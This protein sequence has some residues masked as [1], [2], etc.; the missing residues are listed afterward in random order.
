MA[1]SAKRRG[2]LALAMLTAGLMGCSSSASPNASGATAACTS[3]ATNLAAAISDTEHASPGAVVC[4]AAGD[5]AGPISLD[6]SH[7]R[8]VTLQ[9]TPGAHVTVGAIT[10]AGSHT[11]LRDLWI[12]GE[13]DIKAGASFIT[14]DH[15]DITGGYFGVVFDASD[16]QVA[17]APK[18]P[19]CSPTEPVTN[20]TISGNHFHDI[21]LADKGEDAIHLDYWRNVAIRGNE[22][23]NIIESGNHT[24][25]LQSVYGGENL[26]FEHNYEHDNNCQGLFLKDGDVT[27]VT[28]SE[29][30]FVRDHV[31]SY[32]N[33]SQL[34]NVRG[35][36]VQH[37]TIW[38]GKGLALIANE[39]S[40]APSATIDHNVFS[41]LSVNQPIGTPYA[42]VE[43][44]NRFGQAPSFRI[45]H[46]DRVL[47]HPHFRATATD[48]YRLTNNPGGVGVDWIPAQQQYGPS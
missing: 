14:L 21:G 48:D 15:N 41:S 45:A 20:I 9:A 47:H 44:H 3:T 33:L 46:S 22:F 10:I 37:N 43:S 34:W 2:V 32:A 7:A 18:W 11:T 36:S 31:G 28:F 12:D 30:L 6:H 39:A 4:L 23:N 16:C 17:N 13:V 27:K 38:D 24:D 1:F 19:G 29:N 35:L 25:C 8:Q 42:L 5:Y 40:V 26:T